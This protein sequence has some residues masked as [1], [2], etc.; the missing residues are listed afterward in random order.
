[1][2]RI[3]SRPTMLFLAPLV[4]VVACSAP[5]EGE[6]M[7]GAEEDT[8][9]MASEPVEG[10]AME[11]SDPATFTVELHEAN[12]SGIMGTATA[13]HSDESVEV[14]VEVA[15]VTEGDELSS[16][17]HQG[18]CESG[19][20]VIAPLSSIE[21]SEGT[22]S[23]VTS[24]TVDQIPVDQPLFLQVQGPDGEAVACADFPAPHDEM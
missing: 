2:Y 7:M 14:T 11:S 3:R 5:E 1:M 13:M 18:T 10:M 6:E 16:H 9:E 23:G 22:G 12:A 21:V 20:P 24:L 19:G 8:G 15:G 17:I 4:L